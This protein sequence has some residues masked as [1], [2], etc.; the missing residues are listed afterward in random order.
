MDD[1]LGV[2]SIIAATNYDQNANTPGDCLYETIGTTGQWILDANTNAEFVVTVGNIPVG[3]SIEM[4][5][6]IMVGQNNMSIGLGNNI[7]GTYFTQTPQAVLGTNTYSL[8]TVP[9]SEIISN[10]LAGSIYLHHQGFG[11]MYQGQPLDL[12]NVIFPGDT[13]LITVGCTDATACNYDSL[14]IV[15]DGSCVLG[16]GCSDSSA[17]NY[18]DTVICPD[19]N[20]CVYCQTDPGITTAS[21]SYETA[22]IPGGAINYGAVTWDDFNN[23]NTNGTFQLQTGGGT[24]ANLYRLEYRFK[25]PGQNW[26][27]WAM[28][29]YMTNNSC[30]LNVIQVGANYA[31]T[32]GGVASGADVFGFGNN[33]DGRFNAGTKWRFRIRNLCTDCSFGP[34]GINTWSP[35]FTLSQDIIS[36]I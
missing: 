21:L 33:N 13:E 19:N 1:T 12:A 34:S 29:S 32:F 9:A 36:T 7:Y 18:D 8:G 28:P 24:P 35:V 16:A 22:T 20:D 27:T 17:L 10:A 6:G 3:S 25:T 5:A 31:F 2:N 26:S 30:N 14:V 15:D 11:I 4:P 23:T